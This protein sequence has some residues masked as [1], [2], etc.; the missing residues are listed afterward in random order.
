MSTR[1]FLLSSTVS[2]L[3]VAYLAY[4]F[5]NSLRPSG[6]PFELFVLFLPIAYGF[7]GIIN[8]HV[9]RYYGQNASIWVGAIVGLLFS[10]V[11]RYLFDLP[12]LLFDMNKDTEFRVHFIAPVLYAI[13]FRFILTPVQLL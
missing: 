3:T 8:K 5:A 2:W 7:A 6:V 12:I 4:A 11:G 9:V 1:T 10:L 13:I